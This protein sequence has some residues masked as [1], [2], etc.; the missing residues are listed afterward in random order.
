MN[1][2]NMS[3]MNLYSYNNHHHVG[4]TIS[5]R[6]CG[7][8]CCFLM[9]YRCEHC[10][11]HCQVCFL[12]QKVAL[13]VHMANFFFHSTPGLHCIGCICFISLVLTLADLLKSSNRKYACHLLFTS[14][15]V[16]L[17]PCFHLD[18][19]TSWK[20]ILCLP[21]NDPAARRRFFFVLRILLDIQLQPKGAATKWP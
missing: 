12:S 1:G 16:S 20:S 18:I 21:V 3:L 6:M 9:F 8:C 7:C 11:F 4:I 15:H 19:W 5:A 10:K 14:I 2:C 17:M 13:P